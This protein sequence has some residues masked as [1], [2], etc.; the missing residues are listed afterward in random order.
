MTNSKEKKCCK[1]CKCTDVCPCGL[2]CNA[3][4]SC[5]CHSE[6]EAK[7]CP[8][9]YNLENKSGMGDGFCVACNAEVEKGVI[10]EKEAKEEIKC[11]HAHCRCMNLSKTCSN[12]H[13]AD[14]IKKS[15]QPED[16]CKCGGKLILGESHHCNYISGVVMRIKSPP[17]AKF[18]IKLNDDCFHNREIGKKGWCASCGIKPEATP[19]TA[20]GWEEKFDIKFPAFGRW[21]SGVDVLKSFIKNTVESAVEKT[22]EKWNTK[23]DDWN[24]S[25]QMGIKD[26]RQRVVELVEKMKKEGVI[27][28]GTEDEEWF[29]KR[30]NE[31]AVFNEVL[32]EIIKLI[33]DT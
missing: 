9:A 29:M 13:Y 19:E 27:A 5:P 12:F 31:N 10:K 20:L 28:N 1:L 2:D 24:K 32:S 11:T 33:K 3:N 26:E 15:P 8:H 14:C 23:S 17:E 30:R 6:K 25:F 22:E 16:V 18:E 4:L 21:L 7:I